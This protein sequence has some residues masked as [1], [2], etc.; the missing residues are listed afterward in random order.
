MYEMMIT[1]ITNYTQHTCKM[2][3]ERE[4]NKRDKEREPQERDSENEKRARALKDR[5]KLQS[6][7]ILSLTM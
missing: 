5:A 2:L 6:S 3:P 7:F 4:R 1:F